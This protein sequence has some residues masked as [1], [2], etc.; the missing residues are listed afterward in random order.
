MIQEFTDDDLEEKEKEKKTMTN[1]A[2]VLVQKTVSKVIDGTKNEE[3]TA[4]K[5]K[6]V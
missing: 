4:D 2:Y 1:G 3:F 5:I 6:E